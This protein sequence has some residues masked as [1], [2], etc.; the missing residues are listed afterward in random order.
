LCFKQHYKLIELVGSGSYGTVWKI[1]DTFTPPGSESK[2]KVGK[3]LK[4]ADGK[5]L[6]WLDETREGTAKDQEE[7]EE[8]GY[9][10]D[11]LD[12]CARECKVA[13]QL[14]HKCLIKATDELC[15]DCLCVIV[16]EYIAGSVFAYVDDRINKKC[17]DLKDRL[18]FVR[19]FITCCT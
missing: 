7:F 3:F 6:L 1:E 4:K 15:S 13:M 19:S 18:P 11:L 17:W 16:Y 2:Y 9:G 5:D 14:D 10:A 12:R 8:E